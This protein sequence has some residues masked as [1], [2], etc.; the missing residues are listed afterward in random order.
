MRELTLCKDCLVK[1]ENQPSKDGVQYAL[2]A[3]ELCE[4]CKDKNGIIEG[5]FQK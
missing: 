3:E 1:V 5:R 4:S 2:P